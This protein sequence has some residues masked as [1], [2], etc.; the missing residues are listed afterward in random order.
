[1]KFSDIP[2]TIKVWT[3]AF[4][5]L[6][7]AVAI[8]Y[9]WTS[10]LHT[11]AEAQ[12]HKDEFLNYQKQQYRA[13]KADRVDRVQREIDRIDFQLLTDD[14]PLKKAEYLKNK[15]ADLKAKIECIQKD[16]C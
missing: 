12:V 11:D 15:R 4:L 3:G 6:V 1:M 13:D 9:G 14:L 7:A 10:M 16:E 8:V 5:S 2:G